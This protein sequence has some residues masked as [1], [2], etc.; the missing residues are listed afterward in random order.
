MG[1]GA[2][3]LR[4]LSLANKENKEVERARPDLW[5][6]LQELQPKAEPLTEGGTPVKAMQTA[7]AT[8]PS[9]Y[10]LAS[11]DTSVA[12]AMETALEAEAHK[13]D[14]VPRK[15]Q[16]VAARLDRM[17]QRLRRDHY[18]NNT[19]RI[20]QLLQRHRE[21]LQAKFAEWDLDGDGVI[22]KRELVQVMGSLGLEAREAEVDEFFEEYDPDGSGALDLREFY[23]V[24][25]SGGRR[26]S[27]A[28]SA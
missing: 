17:E 21:R 10:T 8:L 4:R 3:A 28:T 2:A 22:T 16:S 9:S 14:Y 24:A 1:G 25:Y 19:Q 13:G 20:T 18:T 11:T 23:G 6:V 7:L 15:G 26:L 12:H 5:A 27:V